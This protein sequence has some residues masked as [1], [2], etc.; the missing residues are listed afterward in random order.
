[1]EKQRLHGVICYLVINSPLLL[2]V[3]AAFTEVPKDVSVSEGEDIEMPCAFRAAGATPLSLEIQWWYLKEPGGRELAH[4]LHLPA[5]AS[6]VKVKNAVNA[7]ARP[8]PALTVAAYSPP[9]MPTSGNNKEMKKTRNRW[10][11]R[12]PNSAPSGRDTS[13][14]AQGKGRA[15]QQAVGPE[16]R[17]VTPTATSTTEEKPS[18]SQRPDNAAI[19]RQQHATASG[20]IP[21]SEH[22]LYISLPV[23][24]KL[25]SFM[26]AY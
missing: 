19:L 1:M 23:L 13:G 12:T 24:H 20:A 25:L 6:R 15:P 21:T 5:Q 18:A 14:P 7:S 10:T 2:Y 26:D 22:L 17:P 16:P 8:Q 11:L 9:M 3:N 4:E